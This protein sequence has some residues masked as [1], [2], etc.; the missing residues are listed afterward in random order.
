MTAAGP[1]QAAQ[2]WA[3][4]LDAWRIDPEILASVTEN[5]YTFPPRLFAA[6]EDADAAP[7]PIADLAREA[8]PPGGSVLDVGAGAGAGSLGLAGLVGHLHAVD[9]QPSMLAA[10]EESAAARG[11]ELTT[12]AGRWPDLAPE[13]PVCDV[14]VCAHVLY[15]VPDLAPFVAALTD[16]ARQR[17]VVEVTGSHPWERLA[18]MWEAVHHQPRPD[19]PT[20]EL[21]VAV[22]RE[23][24]IEPDARER[25]IAPVERT[26]ALLDTWIDFTRRQLCLPPERRPE[27]EELM[28]RHPPKPR[29]S[30]V[31]SW[32]G[33]G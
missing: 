14:V 23:A 19:G 12:Y 21:A 6:R 25:V 33:A 1:Q 20:A 10:L 13:V 17:V 16:H 22:L 9:A 3:A 24:G 11:I 26:G 2:R 32:P 7:S 31:L 30:V 8:L 27:V 5:P 15:N 18:P 29:R 4:E 28:Q